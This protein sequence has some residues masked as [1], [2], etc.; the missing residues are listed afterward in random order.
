MTLTTRGR[1]SGGERKTPLWYIR[2]DGTIYCISGWGASSDWLKNLKADPHALLQIG[3]K[4]WETRG[5]LI[6][7]TSE[8]ERN[9]LLFQAKYGR[10][11]VS[12]FY[13][14][15]RLVLVGFPVGN[16]EERTTGWRKRP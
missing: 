15:D 3:K 16:A 14:T 11:T 9:L 5:T 1:V 10:R 8:L 7:D 6:Q 4:R 2:E 13:H 12:L